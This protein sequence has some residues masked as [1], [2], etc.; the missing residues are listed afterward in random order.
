MYKSGLDVKKC[1]ASSPSSFELLEVV[2]RAEKR[3]CLF[4][5]IYRTGP[6]GADRMSAFLEDLQRYVTSLAGRSE[7]VVIWGDFNIHVE[8]TQSHV[9]NII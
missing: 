4:A 8:K 7:L 5:T 2:L 1:R 9:D 3:A 6:L